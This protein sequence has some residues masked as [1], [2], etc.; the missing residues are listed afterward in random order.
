MVED[1]NG[2]EIEVL[3]PQKVTKTYGIVKKKFLRRYLERDEIQER[4]SKIH[5]G[6]DKMLILTLWMTGMRITEAVN[7]RKKDIDFENKTLRILWL[8]SRKYQERI[9]P[10]K[11]ELCDMLNFYSASLNGDDKVFGITRQRA[12]SVV[13]KCL[14][15]HPHILRH[16][17]AINFLRQ[18]NSPTA[19]V[20]LQ[21]LLGHKR[22]Q[23]TM[24]YLRLVPMDMAVE[25]EKIKF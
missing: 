11:G 19:F 10:L 18:S 21:K 23:T 16:S 8:K 7:I 1:F 14:L 20:I 24:E 6:R 15:V 3:E 4:L 13:K 5:P 2:K 25:L 12:H 22:I 17:F 9:I